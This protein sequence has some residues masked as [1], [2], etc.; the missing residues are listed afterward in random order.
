MESISSLADLTKALDQIRLP[1]KT[2]GFIPTGGALHAGHRQLIKAARRDVDTL[3]VSIFVNPKEFSLYEKFERYPRHK[4]QD[5]EMCAELGVDWVFS[6]TTEE[7]FPDDY[8]TYIREGQVT[9]DLCG[10]SRPHFFPGV[11]TLIAKYL[12][13]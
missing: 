5:L 4:Q 3:V 8:S 10:Q 11:L 9:Y 6:P 2:L 7:M 13:L 1:G 12:N